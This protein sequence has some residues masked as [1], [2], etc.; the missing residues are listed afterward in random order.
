MKELLY[1]SVSDV[2]D[3]VRRAAVI[4]LGFVLCNTPDEVPKVL[5]LLVASYNPHVR[6][7]A[8]IALGISCA[9][10]AHP[11]VVRLLHSLSSD[12]SD[13]VRQGENIVTVVYIA[14]RCSNRPWTCTAAKQ[15][16]NQQRCHASSRTLQVCSNREAPRCDG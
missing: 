13:F 5:K 3:D 10:H 4:S 15:C 6:Y 1:A 12:R 7:G 11:D 8:A 2:S 16:G 14:C 9:A